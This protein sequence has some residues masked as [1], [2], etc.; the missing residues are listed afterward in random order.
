VLA[1]A[2]RNAIRNGVQSRVEF[3]ESDLLD[4]LA[5]EFH[6]D[7]ILSNPPYI[8]QSEMPTLQREVRDW[9]PP[10]ALTDFGDGLQF[11]RRLLT[12]TPG[13]LKPGGTLIVEMG[14]QQADAINALV[15]ESLWREPKVL[16]DLQGIE[17]TM[18]LTLR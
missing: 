4:G 13:F 18:V 16:R 1:V 8:A 3:I 7:F 2:R 10:L 12:A 14:Y 17:R 9:E 11:Y 15:D 6:A 5:L